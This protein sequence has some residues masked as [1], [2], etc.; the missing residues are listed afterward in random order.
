ML[1]RTWPRSHSRA[2]AVP[3]VCFGHA[4]HPGVPNADDNGRVS[5]TGNNTYG[6]L[7]VLRDMGV[8]RFGK[9]LVECECECGTVKTFR[10]AD[11]KAGRTRS[12][13]CLRRARRSRLNR[14]HGDSTPDSD[15]FALYQVWVSMRRR[16][17]I[18]KYVDTGIPIGVCPEWDDWLTFKEWAL[19]H[20][21]RRGLYI[22]RFDKDKP[23]SPDNC[24]W[25]EEGEWLFIDGRLLHR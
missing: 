19:S 25:V 9:R 17:H 22:T 4:R 18:R 11:L 14:K 6:R 15:Y 1:T 24:K 8:D 21:Y 7:T 2:F 16:H 20:G 3:S 12:C 13:G 10:L 5:D 23:F